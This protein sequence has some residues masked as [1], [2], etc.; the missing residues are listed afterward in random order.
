MALRWGD[1]QAQLNL[2][3]PSLMDFR[4]APV[5]SRPAERGDCTWPMPSRPTRDDLDIMGT[6]HHDCPAP[7]APLLIMRPDR[8]LSAGGPE[9]RGVM[10]SCAGHADTTFGPDGVTRLADNHLGRKISHHAE[11]G[12]DPERNRARR[13]PGADIEVEVSV[14]GGQAQNGKCLGCLRLCHW[15]NETPSGLGWW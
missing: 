7:D 9:P 10:V 13:C 6:C 15:R 4:P 1:V 12:S 2:T 8:P 11:S 3:F 5:R 14:E